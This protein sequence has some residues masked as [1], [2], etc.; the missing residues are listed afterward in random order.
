MTTPPAPKRSFV[1]D[2]LVNVLANLIAAAII[3]L[4]AVAAGYVTPSAFAYV[5]IFALFLTSLVNLVIELLRSRVTERTQ[6]IN[7]LVGRVLAGISIIA[8]AVGIVLSLL[9]IEVSL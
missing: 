4:V 7:D 3:Y 2:V 5:V 8:M 9:D 1:R 6:A